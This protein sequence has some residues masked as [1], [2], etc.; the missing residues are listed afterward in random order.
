ML[1]ISTYA[2]LWRT[3]PEAPASMSLND[4][5]DDV[6]TLGLRVLQ[7]CDSAEFDGFSPADVARLADHARRRGVTLE[8]G[9][10]GVAPDHL[11]RYL[12]LAGAAG[13]PLVR[14]MVVSP[15]YRPTF[16]DALAHL[17]EVAP[18]Y[19]AAGVT[20]ALETYEQIPTTRLV[21]LVD[22]VGSAHVGIC[23]DPGNCTSLLEPP[24][25]VIEACRGRVRNV[26]LK[27]YGFARSDDGIGFRLAGR[28][29][30]EGM[31]PITAMRQVAAEAG[32]HQIIE[33]WLPWQG[34]WELQLAAERGWVAHEVAVHRQA[35][36]ADAEQDPAEQAGTEQTHAEQADAGWSQPQHSSRP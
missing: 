4:V 24:Q 26:H 27:D 8:L 30:G 11:R 5:V 31:L 9:T 36:E 13:A 20:L 3:K 1:G 14:S 18:A 6:A 25:S 19:E 15:D 16:D 17:R 35:L 10:R 2:Y 29:M 7:V 21:E 22:R 33:H 12:E 23:L 32:C 34:D 28:P